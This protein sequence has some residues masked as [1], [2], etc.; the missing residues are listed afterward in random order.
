MGFEI[1]YE[2]HE[3]EQ[4]KMTNTASARDMLFDPEMGVT[5]EKQVRTVDVQDQHIIAS[6]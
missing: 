1:L 2:V 6:E 4:E 5:N 3:N